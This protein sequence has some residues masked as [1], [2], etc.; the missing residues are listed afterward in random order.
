MKIQTKKRFKKGEFR[1]YGLQLSNSKVLDCYD[2]LVG[3]EEPNMV[4]VSNSSVD[5]MKII[6]SLTVP[7]HANSDAYINK[8]GRVE[9]IATEDIKASS[10]ILWEYTLSSL[11]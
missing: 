11:E 6:D 7:A 2:S 8:E 10:E 1:Q 4:S 9:L 5:A 3:N